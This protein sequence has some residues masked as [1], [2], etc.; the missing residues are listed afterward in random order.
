MEPIILENTHNTPA[1]RFI[2]EEG[3]LQI[4]GM[5]IPE[6]AT[7]FYAPVIKTLEHYLSSPFSPLQADIYLVN[8]NTGSAKCILDILYLLE[9]IHR[10]GHQVNVNW[11]YEENDEEM[12]A[13]GKGYKDILKLPFNLKI[14]YLE[15]DL[16]I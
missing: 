5:S 1:I 11:Y 14:K 10:I 2:L 16:T 7:E 6:N 9:D 8:F 3:R 4:S 13:T 15:I 12:E